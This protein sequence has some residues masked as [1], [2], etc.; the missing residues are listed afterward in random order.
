MHIKSRFVRPERVT[1]SSSMP[2]STSAT[3]ACS[4]RRRSSGESTSALSWRAASR[5]WAQ[6]RCE[7]CDADSLLQSKME[8]KNQPR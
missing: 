6:K 5:A 8:A 1:A 2:W 4:A 3:R 7:P